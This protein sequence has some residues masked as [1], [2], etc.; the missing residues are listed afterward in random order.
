[1]N[2]Q[3]LI[4]AVAKELRAPWS[5]IG[6]PG[7]EL[8]GCSGRCQVEV[9]CGHT[10]LPPFRNPFLLVCHKPVWPGSSLQLS[11][12]SRFPSRPA[13][14]VGT[15]SCVCPPGRDPNR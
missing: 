12:E 15:H 7:D 13:S 8:L 4:G 11:S 6:E 9:N 14:V 10:A 5:K 1:M 3:I 2:L